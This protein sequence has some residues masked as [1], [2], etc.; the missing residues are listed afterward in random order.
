MRK[1]YKYLPIF[2]LCFFNSI[3]QVGVGT[4]VPQAAFDVTSTTNGMLI[5]R[6]ALTSKAV[7]AP[8]VNPQGGALVSGTLIWNTATMGTI[9]DNVIPGF[10]YWD[11]PTLRWVAIGGTNSNNWTLS[12]NTGVNGGN[13][14]TAGTNYIG[15]TDNQNLDIHTNNT[16]V[17]RFSQLGEFFLGTLNTTI[18]GDLMNSVANTTFPW[19]IN[20]YSSFNGGGVYGSIQGGT[21]S[22]AAVQG[23]YNSASTITINTAGVRGLNASPAA[24]TGFRNLVGS[25][26]RMGISGGTTSGIGS[27]TFGV[28]GSFGSGSARCGAVFGDDFGFAYGALGYYAANATDYGVYGFSKAYAAGFATGRMTNNAHSNFALEEDHTIGLGIYGGMMGGWVRGLKYGF[29]TKGETYSLYVDGN[30]F[31]NKPLAYLFTKENGERVASYMSSALK[32]EITSNGKT[33]LQNG[34]IFVAFEKDFQ[35]VISNI[36]NLII[37]ATPQGR[38]QGIYVDG[39]TSEG[40]WI[41]ENND[42]TSSVKVAWT[43]ITAIKGEENPTVPSDLLAHDFDQK[44]EGVMFNDNNTSD[45][46]QPIWWDG[47]RMRWDMPTQK[48]E[49]KSVSLS[50]RPQDKPAN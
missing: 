34:K 18:T 8:V 5:P 33:S 24:G 20:G 36:D 46:P 11:T 19:A 41:Y 44:M 9:P 38:S 23:E 22:F 43:A 32:P 39:I 37:T 48:R 1:N 15:T 2:L 29:H 12:G 25:G 26:P 40:F 13:T 49:N 10:Y 35:Q 27:Y 28:Y 21:T 16:Y 50:G 3:S 30:G 31:T 45:Q 14:T 47:T 6:V 7:S 17:A 4:I 42:G